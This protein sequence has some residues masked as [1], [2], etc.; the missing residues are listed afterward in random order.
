MMYGGPEIKR[1]HF[2]KGIE[3]SVQMEKSFLFGE[4]KK[5]TGAN[6]KPQRT[7]K[8]I[9]SYITNNTLDAGGNLTK[10]NFDS[11][12]ESAFMYGSNKKLLLSSAK[13]MT[14]VNSFGDSAIRLEPGEDTYGLAITRYVCPHGELYLV[15]H[16]LLT[17]A[18][19]GAMGAILDM[20][21]LTYCP[22]KGR[23][24]KIQTN[25]QDND[26]DAQKDQYLTEAGIE[27]K[28]PKKHG[29]IKNV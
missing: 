15:K 6:G 25:I 16:P 10:A 22:L 20:D 4:L 17:G 29:L 5:I 11:Y 18:V 28:S 12:L 26:E 19:Y 2:K 24:T 13:L 21:E 7:T 23:D 3:H 1:Q 9:M 27:F 14:K 8:G